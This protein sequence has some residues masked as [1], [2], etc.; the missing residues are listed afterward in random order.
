M[1]KSNLV[2]VGRLGRPHGIKGWLRVSSFT[3]P[4]ENLFNYPSWQLG[5]EDVFTRSIEYEQWLPQGNHLLV[6][7]PGCDTPE[8]AREFTNLNIAV[9]R[10][11]LPPLAEQ[12]YYWTDLEGLKV[13]C[14]EDQQQGQSELGIIDHLFATGSNDVMVV[15]GD[16]ERL[17]PFIKS[18]V[19][20]VNLAQGYLLVDWDKDF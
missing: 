19:L 16:K 11:L 20:E 17:I 4:I 13:I 18:V 8:Q 9:P 10:E 14:Q 5:Y 1:P 15:K 7:L 12:D 2:I 6:K 3:D